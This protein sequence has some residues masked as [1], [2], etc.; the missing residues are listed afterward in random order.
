AVVD[1]EWAIGGQHD[2]IR[3]S[4]VHNQEVGWCADRSMLVEKIDNQAI[5]RYGEE[6]KEDVYKPQDI[7]PHGVNR[8]EVVPM[9]V[10]VRFKVVWCK[11]RN[12][13]PRWVAE[14]YLLCTSSSSNQGFCQRPSSSEVRHFIR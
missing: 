4:E 6:Q 2:E 9:F 11:I 12:G 14:G 5:S 13:H 1:K 7:V 3:E 10:N 8:W